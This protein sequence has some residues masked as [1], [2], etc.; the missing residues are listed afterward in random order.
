M[1]TRVCLQ[2]GLFPED[3]RVSSGRFVP[4]GHTGHCTNTASGTM[5]AVTLRHGLILFSISL[6][7]IYSH[8]WDTHTQTHTDTHTAKVKWEL[9]ILFGGVPV[10]Q[11]GPFARGALAKM[12]SWTVLKIVYQKYRTVETRQRKRENVVVMQSGG[13]RQRDEST[14]CP[15]CSDELSSA[16]QPPQTASLWK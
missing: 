7:D 6:R 4:W 15:S 10:E 1:L 2:G 12:T 8:T 9:R 13:K 5:W 3:T 16:K 11:R 14:V